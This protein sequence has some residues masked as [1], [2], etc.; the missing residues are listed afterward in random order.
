MPERELISGSPQAEDLQF[1]AGL[2]PR[3]LADF[4]GQSVPPARSG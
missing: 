2:R 3:R 1:E 4:T